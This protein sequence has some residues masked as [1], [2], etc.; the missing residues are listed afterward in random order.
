MPLPKIYIVG[1]SI[2]IQYGRFL[3]RMLAER[4][5]YRRKSGVDKAL[6]NLDV[7]MGA[8]GGDSSMCLAFLTAMRDSADLE[9]DVLLLNC[10]LHDIKTTAATGEIQVPLEQYRQNLER[11]V[12][13]V[14]TMKPILMWMRTT[15]VDEQQHNRRESSIHRFASDVDRYNAA[16][17]EVMASHGVEVIDL[18]GF[19]LSLG[20]PAELLYDGRHFQEPI[21]RLQA[22]YL[23]G[24]LDAWN[25]QR[26]GQ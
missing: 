2:S 19:T 21:Q 6:E 8:N 13:L 23:A 12:Q 15:P 25:A 24:R 18:H 26:G 7:A 3:E 10:G 22:A 16:A 11:I 4:F 14:Q 5:E 1:D 17:D 9:V 20:E